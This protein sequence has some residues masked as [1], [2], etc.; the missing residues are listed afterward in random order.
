MS[1]ALVALAERGIRAEAE[2]KQQLKDSYHRFLAEEDPT[3]KNEAGKDLIRGIFGEESIA[4][5]SVLNL[6]RAVWHHILKRVDKRQ[7]SVG[8]LTALQKWVRTAPDGDWYKE[9]PFSH[10]R[11]SSSWAGFFRQSKRTSCPLVVAA[12]AA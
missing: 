6:P 5:D 12:T 1:R 7:I 3:R 11:W 4:E 9:W 10:C 2:A 8:D